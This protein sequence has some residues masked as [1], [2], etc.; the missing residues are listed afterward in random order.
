MR[1]RPD[2][3]SLRHRRSLS[4]LVVTV[5]TT[6]AVASAAVS[7]V[8]VVAQEDAP[9]PAWVMGTIVDASFVDE[10]AATW[11][12][13]DGV[14]HARGAHLEHAFQWSD[15]RLPEL[16]VTLLDADIYEVPDSGQLWATSGS[17]SLEGADGSWSGTMSGA[18]QPDGSAFWQETLVGAG[19][20]EGLF[21]MLDC[22]RPSDTT[23]SAVVAT[24]E[25]FIV[26]GEPPPP[27]P[28]SG[29]AGPTTAP[30]ASPVA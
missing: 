10:P 26:E 17:L 1:S 2:R 11:W 23:A 15:P 16:Q 6:L 27:G 25:G 4:V 8:P 13:E 22:D 12:T 28:D 7:V 5:A 29:Q 24:C 21:A 9:R 14:R 19:A 3:R 18:I 30:A 20:W